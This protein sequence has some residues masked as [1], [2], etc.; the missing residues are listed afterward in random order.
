MNWDVSLLIN[1]LKQ[2]S[3]KLISNFSLLRQFSQQVNILEKRCSHLFQQ[4]I[5]A[6][7]SI[8]NVRF[9]SSPQSV[10]SGD[11]CFFLSFVVFIFLLNHLTTTH[12]RPLEHNLLINLAKCFPHSIRRQTRTRYRLLSFSSRFGSWTSYQIGYASSSRMK[13]QEISSF[14]CFSTLRL[15]S[16]SSSTEYGPTGKF[17]TIRSLK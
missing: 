9:R 8:N 17:K 13:S 11:N 6:L 1:L 3:F 7:R 15:P 16:S 12:N 5:Y 14:S 4:F 10:V 2:L